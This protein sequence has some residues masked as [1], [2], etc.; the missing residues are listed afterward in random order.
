MRKFYHSGKL[1]DILYSLPTIK[2]LNGGELI[3]GV[4]AGE[5]AA[6]KPLLDVQ[7]YIYGTFYQPN[8]YIAMADIDLD[9]F[10]LHP[11]QDKIHL[12]DSHAQSNKVTVD[13]SK[14]WL[15]VSGGFEEA[16]YAVVNVT[17]RHRD[18]FF[19]W[20]K[21]IK[22]LRRTHNAVYFLGLHKEHLLL[23]AQA[24]N[25]ITF[26]ETRNLLEAAIIIKNARTFSSNQSALLAIRQGLGMDYRFECSP[27]HTNTR[28]YSE[29]ETI[30]NPISRKFHKLVKRFI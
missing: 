27:H 15:Q 23:E 12:V 13:K 29:R 26:L 30:L 25:N 2:A 28:T 22:Y 4:T 19:N 1:G 7:P 5:Y 8:K 3:L 9:K 16:D 18:K 20:S 11:K 6:I 24:N 10:R 17:D 21:E 14:A